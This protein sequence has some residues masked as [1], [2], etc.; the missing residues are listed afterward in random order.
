MA[1][2]SPCYLLAA[3]KGRYDAAVGGCNRKAHAGAG[4]LVSLFAVVVL[5]Q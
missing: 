4:S 5:E 2:F 1:G 3:V